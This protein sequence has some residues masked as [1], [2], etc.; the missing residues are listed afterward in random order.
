MIR[1]S[2]RLPQVEQKPSKNVLFLKRVTLTSTLVFKQKTCWILPL[3]NHSQQR[4]TTPPIE[5]IR[6]VNVC[7][8]QD[9]AGAASKSSPFPL[10]TEV[11]QPLFQHLGLIF[12]SCSCV[13]Q[14]PLSVLSSSLKLWSMHI[15]LWCPKLSSKREI[16]AW[17]SWKERK[18]EHHLT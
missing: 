1:K 15:N 16:G 11:C 8:Y 4:F 14:Y 5:V 12:R 7:L 17:R 9:I 6:K 18:I 10:L 3:R 13:Q 2:H